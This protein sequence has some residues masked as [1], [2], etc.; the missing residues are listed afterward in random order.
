M[1]QN[2]YPILT[3]LAALLICS[4]S[5]DVVEPS[6]P[7]AQ[8]CEHTA[9]LYFEG[10]LETFDG[11]TIVSG[12]ATRATT[13]NWANGATLYLHSPSGSSTTNY[14]YATFNSSSKTWT[15]SYSGSLVNDKAT[16]CYVYYF[17]NPTQTNSSSVSLSA[18]SAVYADMQ[19]SYIYD[20]TSVVLKATLKPQTARLRIKGSQGSVTVQDLKT[21]SSYTRS[22]GTLA[23]NTNENTFTITSSG[24][25]SYIYCT[26]ADE[27]QRQLT[28]KISSSTGY[29]R[30]FSTDAFK[31][32]STGVLSVPTAENH[33]GWTLVNLSSGKEITVP[34]IGLPTVADIQINGATI[35]AMVTSSNNGTITDS[36]FIVY[37]PLIGERNISCG[38]AT[39]LSTKLTDL[40][41]ETTYSIR[42]YATN[43][44][45]TAYS[46]EIEFTTSKNSN[47]VDI[48][49]EDWGSEEDWNEYENDIAIPVDLGLTSGTLWADR[50]L[51]A[52]S[53][54]KYGDFYAWGETET[55][56]TYLL[57][58]YSHYNADNE[59]FDSPYKGVKGIQGTEQD[60]AH[61]IWG[62]NW[63]IP[64]PTQFSELVEQC[65]WEWQNDYNSTGVKGYLV[66]SKKN[67]NY[68]FLPITGYY[69]GASRTAQNRG[70]YWTSSLYLFP[71]DW[72]KAKQA[73]EFVIEQS[74]NE[75]DM[76][77]QMDTG[78][79][80]G[81]VI[82]PVELK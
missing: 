39:S 12:R 16:Q 82:R 72:D 79:A 43:E 50:N 54:D 30:H 19:A 22:P 77:Y 68:I 57:S 81:L 36:G 73:M 65:T 51:G 23:T 10:D 17:E 8:G 59:T 42:A 24:Y 9:V 28:F 55:K 21:Y 40:S 74:N 29:R 5:Y 13:S 66:K 63:V 18:Q 69:N 6:M 2:R 49:R 62:G 34:S 60:A 27:Q 4:C 25:S 38:T 67:S 53:P 52:E 41:P 78:R 70:F 75:N 1:H 35:Q 48:D 64:T 37:Y 47:E 7:E 61:V 11:D 71:A 58:N 80:W 46:K 56:S 15:V 3:L 45:G 31:I 32:G 44:A 20:G 76:H 14:G 33:V 26:L